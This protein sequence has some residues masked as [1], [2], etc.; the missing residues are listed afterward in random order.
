MSHNP[1]VVLRIKYLLYLLALVI[2]VVVFSA[3]LYNAIKKETA[4]RQRVPQQRTAPSNSPINASVPFGNIL[5]TLTGVKKNHIKPG[6]PYVKA[7]S[8]NGLLLFRDQYALSYDQRKGIAIWVSWELHPGWFGNTPRYSGKFIT[9]H[10]LPDSMY[11][12]THEDYTHSGYDR[13]HIVRSKE[14]TSSVIDNKSTFLMTNIMP[15]TPDLNRGVWL[16]FEKFCEQ[17]ALKEGKQLYVI[18]GGFSY[19]GKHLPTSNRVAVP[20]SFF[21]IVLDVS[22]SGGDVDSSTHVYAVK[23]PNQN[24]I[25]KDRWQKYSCSIGEVEASTGLSFLSFIPYPAAAFLK[26]QTHR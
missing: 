22:V 1:V 13:G 6:I 5:D 8:S 18:S 10:S 12:V 19:T 24:G 14:R 26:N 17:L 7:D 2:F 16:D 20:D 3:L 9:D 23:M 21:K 4:G 25:R 15:Q 11:R